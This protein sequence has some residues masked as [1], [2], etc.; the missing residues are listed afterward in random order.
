[1]AETSSFEYVT[2]EVMTQHSHENIDELFAQV[3]LQLLK[4]RESDPE[5]VEELKSTLT[6]LED[7]VESLVID[8]LK[9]KNPADAAKKVK[10]P[11]KRNK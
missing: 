4:I 6:Q 1:M 7:S 5:I 9:F 3:R 2:I 10:Q 11:K 8:L